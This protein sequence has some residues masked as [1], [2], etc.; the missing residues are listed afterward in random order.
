MRQD[1]A[2]AVLLDTDELPAE[3]RQEGLFSTMAANAGA[4]LVILEG[5]PARARARVERWSF[6]PVVLLH[7]EGTGMRLARVGRAPAATIRMI[8]VGLQERGEGLLRAGAAGRVLPTGGVV[9]VDSSRPYEYG[10]AGDGS[11]STLLIPV[12]ELALPQPMLQRASAE[13]APSAL[14][15]LVGDHIGALRRHA[16]ELA[17]DP[18]AP[19]VG[20]ACV[21]L[22]R[23]LVAAVSNDQ[24]HLTEIVEQSLITQ[25]RAHIRQHLADPELGPPAIASALHISLRHL[26]ATCAR[27]NFSVEQFIIAQRLDAAKAELAHPNA[28]FRAIAAVARRW[29]FKDPAHFARRF[30]A[31]YGISP[32]DW[33][34]ACGES[35]TA[36]SGGASD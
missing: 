10:W 28:R 23:A 36:A 30:R 4:S 33:R 17:D 8:S 21:E 2:M 32:R 24:A 6:G 19:T 15:A 18:S 26:Y 20:A 3:L 31:A 9:V 13:P 35:W 14:W 27:A 11:A 25:I 12:A 22:V 16:D 7:A 29:G 1:V 34:R 5:D